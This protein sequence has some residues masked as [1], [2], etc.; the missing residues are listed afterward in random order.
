[1]ETFYN[2]EKNQYIFAAYRCGTNFLNSKP[3]RNQG[4]FKVKIPVSGIIIKPETTVVKVIRDP[5]ERWSSWFDNFV[6][7]NDYTHWTT[8]KAHSWLRNFEENLTYDSHTEKQSVMYNFENIL[9]PNSI[10]VNMEDLNLFLGVSD[11]KHRVNSHENFY[12]L[13]NRVF[14]IFNIKIKTIYR[15]DYEWMKT[16]PILNF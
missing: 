14:S 10:Y 7:C 5:F 8:Q 1:M 15:D 6:I 16:L 12:K 3:V 9:S 13:S 11:K 4:W 2:K